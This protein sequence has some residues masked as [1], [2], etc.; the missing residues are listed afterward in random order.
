[1]PLYVDLLGYLT[2]NVTTVDERRA[3]TGALGGRDSM[4]DDGLRRTVQAALDE[5]PN[6]VVWL[7][8]VLGAGG[9]VSVFDSDQ[10]SATLHRVTAK[11][12]DESTIEFPWSGAGFAEIEVSSVP[13]SLMASHPDL[14]FDGLEAG[15]EESVIHF[16]T[17]FDDE[18]HLRRVLDEL[19]KLV[20]SEVRTFTSIDRRFLGVE[21][22]PGQAKVTKLEASGPTDATTNIARRILARE[23]PFPNELTRTPTTWAFAATDEM[24]PE[25]AFER[26]CRKAR[27]AIADSNADADA[28][29]LRKELVDPIVTALES[30]PANDPRRS[31]L[32]DIGSWL[33]SSKVRA[34]M[35][36][37]I[38]SGDPAL[39][40]EHLERQRALVFEELPRRVT[41]QLARDASAPWLPRIVGLL[42]KYDLAHADWPR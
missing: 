14:G 18:A 38:E 39:T 34:L 30:L 35:M 32:W 31:E 15:D 21:L 10:P 5:H 19:T 26:S 11:S 17:D 37:S 16:P 4:T 7:M 2:E 1:M 29:A 42:A 28:K 41:E 9:S 33:R 24:F 36:K 23:A 22:G 6:V 27:A 12:H 13:E 25:E 8:T 3:I 40:D 20:T